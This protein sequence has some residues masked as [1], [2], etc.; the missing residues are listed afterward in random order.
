MSIGIVPQ[1]S[2]MLPYLVALVLMV[3]SRGQ[4][5]SPAEDGKPYFRE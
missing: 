4:A 5:I 2:M 1:I 3:L